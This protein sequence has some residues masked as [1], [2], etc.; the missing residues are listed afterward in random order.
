MRRICL[1]LL[2]ATGAWGQVEY[3]A[4]R[5]DTLAWSINDTTTMPAI[6]EEYRLYT[7]SDSLHSPAGTPLPADGAPLVLL[8]FPRPGVAL[9]S[10]STDRLIYATRDSL[11]RAGPYQA[12][13]TVRD[14]LYQR[15]W[16]VQSPLPGTARSFQVIQGRL[17]KRTFSADPATR[18]QGQ[19]TYQALSDS[20]ISARGLQV[21]M[22]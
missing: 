14:T 11:G 22:R 16:S 9:L 12:A 4:V 15:L 21:R 17:D 10:V 2:M 13:Y 18:K 3:T 5:V 6:S 7:F 8:E 1:L 20:M 19:R